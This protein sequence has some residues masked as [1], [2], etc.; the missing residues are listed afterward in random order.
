M[1]IRGSP[2]TNTK[3]SMEY[4]I[5]FDSTPCFHSQ[6]QP[7]GMGLLRAFLVIFNFLLSIVRRFCSSMHK[8]D[9][10]SFLNYE[11]VA[12]KLTVDHNTSL[13]SIHSAPRR[14]SSLKVLDDL[15]RCWVNTL[16]SSV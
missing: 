12:I 8:R 6:G 4:S 14:M 3:R 13:C 1:G 9:L 7:L 15:K 10:S 11:R 16:V 5:D 2:W